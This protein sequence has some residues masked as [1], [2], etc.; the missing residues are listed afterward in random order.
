MTV[1]QGR[2]PKGILPQ[3]LHKKPADPCNSAAKCACYT[4]S[5]VMA[6]NKEDPEINKKYQKVRVLFQSTSSCN[7][8]AVNVLSSVSKFEETKDRG[9]GQ[10][11]WK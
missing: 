3:Y 10:N 1:R 2:L 8:Q 5:I 6:I 4:G 9:I 11:K 7:I